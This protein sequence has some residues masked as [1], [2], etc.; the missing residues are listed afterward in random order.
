MNTTNPVAAICRAHGV[1]LNHGFVIADQVMH[2]RD[3]VYW[4]TQA[5]EWML[6]NLSSKKT[7]AF[8]DDLLD[9]CH[10]LGVP[11]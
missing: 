4:V 2:A 10:T 8:I 5:R 3:N 11:K 1:P 9:H 6:E 7:D